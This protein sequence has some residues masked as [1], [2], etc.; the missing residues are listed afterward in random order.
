M[1]IGLIGAGRLGLCL[2][3]LMEEAGY[4]VIASDVRADYIT[5]L[6]QKVIDTTEPEVKELLKNSRNIYFTNSNLEV[7][8]EADIIFILVRTP[9]LENGRYDVSD[10]DDVISDV[11]KYDWTNSNCQH[12]SIVIGCTTNPGDCDFF[13]DR[14]SETGF[15][16]YYNPEFIAQGSI[17]NDLRR[18][19]MVLIGGSGRHSKE[20]ELIYG[21]IQRGYKI[22]S[23]H[24]MSTKAAEITKIAV[25]CFL[26]TKISYANM[27]GQ[28][29]SMSGLGD[30]INGVLKA[31][32]SDDRIGNK[33][34]KFGFGFGGPCFPRDNRA[35]AAY[36]T[37][38]GVKFNIG[39]TTDNFNQELPKKLGEEFSPNPFISNPKYSFKYV[40]IQP[41]PR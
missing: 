33:Y 39:D 29:L 31:I 15:D 26:T 20:I 10:V 21:R 4:D 27:L 28:V 34:L 40:K 13:E 6:N 2:A 41:V 24:F 36:A 23:I 32:G 25:N 12:K 9:S 30:E 5:S 22:P 18:S 37:D 8:H 38:V 7:I 14:L 11:L 16:L 19:D 35:F 17:V 1:K 3:L